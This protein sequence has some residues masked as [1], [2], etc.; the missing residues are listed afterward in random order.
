ML[1]LG[2][3][4]SQGRPGVRAAD[5]A[6]APAAPAAAAPA[7]AAAPAPAAPAPAAPAAPAAPP[8]PRSHGERSR[9]QL[10]SE[11]G[12]TGNVL[13]FGCERFWLLTF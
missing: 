8:A 12:C 10:L 9:L 3:L 5:P 11:L 13:E 7:D 6:R 4:D 2:E 1:F